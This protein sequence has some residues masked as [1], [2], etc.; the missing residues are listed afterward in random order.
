MK[1]G[2]ELIAEERARQV[3]VEGWTA[4]HDDQHKDGSLAVNPAL[5]A[6]CGTDA[7]LIDWAPNR[8]TWKIRSKTRVEQLAKA[9]ALIAA[10]IDRHQRAATQTN[11]A[12]AKPAGEGA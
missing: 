5:L 2:V 12:E 6:V 7:E 8:L 1:T 4:E 10:E 3:A 11:K 9:G